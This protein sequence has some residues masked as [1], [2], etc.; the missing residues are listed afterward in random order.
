[1]ASANKYCEGKVKWS[2]Y[3]GLR[4]KL[5]PGNY[6]QSESASLL[7]CWPGRQDM[8]DQ[9]CWR[10]EAGKLSL[11]L[12]PRLTCSQAMIDEA[13]AS[14]DQLEV[15][16]SNVAA[17]LEASA[18]VHSR[19]LAFLEKLDRA[20]QY[21]A[22]HCQQILDR[23]ST[24]KSSSIAVLRELQEKLHGAQVKSHPGTSRE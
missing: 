9:L 3:W 4:E 23:S 5:K 8:M 21:A 15:T 19:D 10:P 22:K 16:A 20:Q 2:P 24:M 12:L 17:G 13:Q 18:P 14:M 11:I 6:Q 7:G 1:M